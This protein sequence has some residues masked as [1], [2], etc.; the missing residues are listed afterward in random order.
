VTRKRFNPIT[1]YRELRR[2]RVFQVAV[3]YGVGAWGVIAAC[4]VL[5]PQLT[6]WVADPDRAMRTVF[7]AVIA[8][9]P[10]ALVFGWLY[11]VTA[12]GIQRT[13]SFSG[14]VRD[15][16]TS[17]HPVDRG[18]I[19]TL[20]A[21][22]I[23]VLAASTLHIVRMEPALS[24]TGPAASLAAPNNSIAVLPFENMSADP[25]QE[26]FSD[27]ISEEIL[28]LLSQIQ[29]LKVIARTSS[30][31]FKG[32]DVTAAT[33]AQQL[34]VRHLLEGS[35]RRSG[36]RVRITAQLI[37]AK[38]SA[39]VWSRTYDRDLSSDDLFYIQ[40]DVARAV[41]EELRV[42][43][44]AA[45]EQRL[46]KVPTKNTEAYAAYL[47][48][49][50]WLT[51]PKVEDVGKAVEQFAKAI[52]LDPRFAAPHS[53][54]A[55]ACYAWFWLGAGRSMENCP[56]APSED[57][58][59]GLSYGAAVGD[60]A[61]RALELD[62]TLGEAWVSLG[63]ALKFQA[64]SISDPTER[65]AK[66]KE[67][68]S[69]YQRG[70]SLNPSYAQGYRWYAT[71]LAD[72]V[73]YGDTW[74][75]WLDAWEADT[76]Q[77][78]IRQG[79]EVDPLSISLHS[80]MTEF[81]MWA[82]TKE[83]ALYHARRIIQIAPDSP[84]GYARLANQSWALSGR[85]DEAIKW[86]NRAAEIDPLNPAYPRKMA[87]AY[88]TLGDSDMALAYWE[89]AAQLYSGD[90]LPEAMYILRAVILLGRKESIPMQQVLEA[91]DPV[92]TANEG[93]REIEAHL[94][95][96][97]GEGADWFARHAD[98]LSECLEAEIEVYLDKFRECGYWLDWLLLVAGEEKRV[99]ALQEARI[100]FIRIFR[101]WSGSTVI[102]SQSFVMLGQYDKALDMAEANYIKERNRG[103]PYRVYLDETLRFTLY[104]DRI[105]AP[106]RDHPR[107][108]AVIAE[109]EADL[110]QQLE[111]VR[112]MERKGELPTLEQLRAELQPQQ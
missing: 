61:R 55:D 81:P 12:E 31:S 35:V 25:E 26:Y 9:F 39:H 73:L 51:D 6:G 104:H 8:L 48:G 29:S 98:D 14:T 3:L 19:G 15:P 87:Y 99:Q 112:E 77:S 68:I 52:E 13:A 23:G 5:L 75:G 60:L 42:T 106:I 100:E 93:R 94:A 7:I 50:R 49:R 74:L 67:A 95:I 101:N 22:V 21:L 53:G 24:P 40:S 85:I 2:R 10:V 58:A 4:D 54:L 97:R 91:L 69:A 38:D 90:A 64:Q 56:A 47:L 80:I 83:E 44:T 17:L 11:D 27:G 78:V 28:N 108:Q 70:L 86:E 111:N 43:L 109:V 20:S 16:D 71:S 36:D 84:R 76:W 102:D 37:D 96:L 57:E 30:F 82:R 45:D 18:I 33:M 79:L 59:G 105:L 46:T 32:K 88:A 89:H 65:L 63:N 72:K 34:N 62:G 103:N 1:L 107:F 66:F 92:D 41:T 110:A